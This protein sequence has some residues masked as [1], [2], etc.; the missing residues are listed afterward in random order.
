MK[1][2]LFRMPT[3]IVFGVGTVAKI[4]EICS[5]LKASKV[6][7]VTG[8]TATKNSPYLSEVIQSLEQCGIQAKIYAEIEADPSI[9]TVDRGA[10]AMQDFGADCVVA[11]GGGSPMDAAKS[12]AMLTANPGSI[13][14]YIRG[15]RSIVN[16][17]LPLVCVPTTAGTGSEVTSAA[18][19]TDTALQEKIGLSHDYLLPAVAVLDPQLHVSM[20]AMVT[21]ATGIDALTHAVEAYLA[22][23]ATP[24]SDALA[25]QAIQLIG[26]YL[27][28]SVANGNNLAVR[29][30]MLL[31]SVMAGGAFTNAGLGAVHGIAHPLGAKFG[32][33][34]GVANA[35]MLPYVMDYCLIADY[36]KFAVIA[37]ALGESIAGLTAREAAK[38]AVRAVHQLNADIGIP[39]NLATVGVPIN[40]VEAIVNDAITYRMLPNSPRQLTVGDLQCIVQ[41][42]VQGQ[43][44]EGGR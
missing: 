34:H 23:N 38:A 14:D 22:Q 43:T 19:T 10:R 29:E 4:G 37:D 31:A 28:P 24:I 18:V 33:A 21:A 5:E 36:N 11:F 12:M 25:L 16:R 9:D 13:A 35:I 17:G 44:A 7:V 1:Q 8:R 32:L 6:F 41:R 30:Q 26:R 42:A 40:A 39:A 15:R 20:P 2:W 27:R 3:R